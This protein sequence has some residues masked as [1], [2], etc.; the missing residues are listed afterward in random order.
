LVP[1]GG[2]VACEQ[3]WY[4]TVVPDTPGPSLPAAPVLPVSPFAPSDT[5][6]IV[7]VSDTPLASFMRTAIVRVLDARFAPVMVLVAPEPVTPVGLESLHVLLPFTLN[8]TVV[9]VVFWALPVT[10]AVAGVVA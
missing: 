8:S 9:I 3:S 2:T 10:T 7:I 1:V 6:G 5:L 4:S